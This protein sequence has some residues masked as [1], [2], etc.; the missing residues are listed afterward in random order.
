[1]HLGVTRRLAVATIRAGVQLLAVGFLLSFIVDAADSDWWA[2]A[3]VGGMVA[4]TSVVAKRRTPEI[5]GGGIVTF[6]AVASATA[7]CLGVIF[8][9]GVIEYEPIT[10]VVIAGITIGN[11][12]PSIVLGGKQLVTALD[13]GRG[14]I[15]ALLA[16]GFD[17]DGVTRVAGA[18]IVRTA[19]IPQIERTNVVGLIALPGAMTGL[20][21]AGTDPVDAVL[22]QII[23]MYLVLGSVAISVIVTVILGIRRSFTPDLRLIDMDRE[24]L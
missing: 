17:V 15:E 24:A 21:L 13:D 23:V 4:M 9:M 6:V 2:W 14:R 5:P 19:L 16:L 7:I 10:L 20:L 3:W 11:T 1:M 8:G 12:L 22:I 18:D